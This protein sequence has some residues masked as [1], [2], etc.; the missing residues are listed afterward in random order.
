M[1]KSNSEHLDF[2]L[3]SSIRKRID[4]L[5]DLNINPSTINLITAEF[6]T[7]S[8]KIREN[9][10]RYIARLLEIESARLTEQFNRDSKNNNYINLKQQMNLKNR[11][12]NL[13]RIQQVFVS[14]DKQ[15]NDESFKNKLLVNNNQDKLIANIDFKNAMIV[16]NQLI[17]EDELLKNKLQDLANKKRKIELAISNQKQNIILA[18]KQYEKAISQDDQITQELKLNVIKY[19]NQKLFEISETIKKY[20]TVNAI[21]DE[22]IMNF[23]A[24]NNYEYNDNH[25]NIF[26]SNKINSNN[27]QFEEVKNKTYT[28]EQQTQKTFDIDL[29]TFFDVP[30]FDEEFERIF[31]QTPDITSK[32][33][34]SLK[35]KNIKETSKKISKENNKKIFENKKN[36]LSIKKTNVETKLTNEN[37][38][39][40]IELKLKKEDQ[41]TVEK[42]KTKVEVISKPKNVKQKENILIDKD[43]HVSE[44]KK[45][46]NN[47]VSDEKLNEMD[48][49]KII[50]KFKKK[51]RAK[52]RQIEKITREKEKIL[53]ELKKLKEQNK[54]EEL[55]KFENKKKESIE[56]T[57]RILKKDKRKVETSFQI[58]E[59]KWKALGI[60]K[61]LF[62]KQKAFNAVK[63]IKEKQALIE[64]EKINENPGALINFIENN[65]SVLN[66][67]IKYDIEKKADEDMLIVT[68]TFDDVVEF[69]NNKENNSSNINNTYEKISFSNN[70]NDEDF[71]F[72]NK[73]NCINERINYLQKRKDLNIINLEEMKELKNKK[74]KYNQHSKKLNLS[75]YRLVIK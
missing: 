32:K 18:K 67:T 7:S 75:K 19:A 68:E 4:A 43:N 40:N 9:I 17:S 53:K 62:S 69:D 26:S 24:M 63:H 73:N 51:A 5:V 72:E 34:K 27:N 60:S 25:T 57:E 36:D 3:D 14:K 30:G 21:P 59:K 45:P 39:S 52:D 11:E 66:E 41:Y 10:G 46:L 37:T 54:I 71:E 50:K 47:L 74:K 55:R 31:S 65:L 16:D 12:T 28:N 70:L 38:N 1:K 61:Q 13:L 15:K 33:T 22:I 58:L 6:A 20:R 29:E 64:S 2:E 35:E 49:E 48:S 8:E 23:T 56:N 42:P 44:L